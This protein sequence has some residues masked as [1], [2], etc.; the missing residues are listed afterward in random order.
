MSQAI[1]YKCPNCGSEVIFDP[2]LGRLRCIGCGTVFESPEQVTGGT[3]GQMGQ[4][5][6]AAAPAD[7]ATAAQQAAASGSLDQVE[8]RSCGAQIVVASGTQASTECAYCHSPVV[9][10]G[11]LAQGL[12]PDSVVPFQVAEDQAR[13]IFH[14]W[15]SKKRYVQAGFY[16]RERIDKL[17]GVYFPY[18]AVDAQLDV[19]AEGTAHYSV[20]RNKN[21]EHHYYTVVREGEVQIANLPQEA[22]KASRAN[23]MINR[24]LPWDLTRQ[25]EF[26]PQYLSGFQSERRDLDFNDVQN[27]VMY[28]LDL[29]GRR[30]LATDVFQGN[31]RYQDLK[32]WGASRLKQWKHRYTLL[33]AWVLFYIAPGGELFY[34]GI[35]GQTWEAVGRLPVNSRKLLRDSAVISGLG[36]LVSVL[37]LY[38]MAKG[39]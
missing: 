35:N 4:A 26:T 5:T 6:L 27:D 33:P 39:I 34:F 1:D 17:D 11:Q 24:L 23:K 36:A 20:H 38:L 15:I 18:F 2:G 7:A 16:S 14:Q 19:Q 22:L 9:L 29:A 8:C 28:H 31:R 3:L 37:G 10:I 30:L 12:Q 25:V 32:L 21:T 13:N